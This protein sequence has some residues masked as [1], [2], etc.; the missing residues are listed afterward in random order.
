M[1]DTC[2]R[3]FAYLDNALAGRPVQYDTDVRVPFYIRGPGITPGSTL[4]HPTTHLDLTA[5]LLDLAG[6]DASAL[7]LDGLSF[8]VR[9]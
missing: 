8:K 1:S 6:I 9:R 4:S 7:N 3:S 2:C 5:T